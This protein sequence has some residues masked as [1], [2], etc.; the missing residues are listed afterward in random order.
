MMHRCASRILGQCSRTVLALCIVLIATSTP[1]SALLQGPLV[2]PA[3]DS[4]AYRTRNNI[5]F[6]DPND[7]GGACA[8]TAGGSTALTGGENIEKGFNYFI[9]KGLTPEQSAGIVGN[10][11]VESGGKLDPAVKQFDGGPGRGIAQWSA[12]GRWDTLLAWAAKQNRSPTDLA[13]QL[14]FLWY[15]LETT[16]K[17]SLAAVRAANTFAEAASAFMLKF[18]RPADTSQSAQ[19]G[20][21]KIAGQVLA[22]YGANGAAST[23]PAG[24]AT[25]ASTDSSPS[26]ACS[27][28]PADTVNG[29]ASSS[30]FVWPLKKGDYSRIST[31]WG[32]Y[33]SR[34]GYHTGL[35]INAS[36]KPVLAAKAGK[37]IQAGVLGSTGILAIVIDHGGGI[38]SNYQHLDSIAVKVGESVR[39]SQEIGKSGNSG[40]AQGYSTGPH[41]HFGISTVPGVISVRDPNASKLTKDPLK[42]LPQDGSVP[43][44]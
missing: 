43:G 8:A 4:N 37:V 36:Y 22:R 13:T 39:A 1:A 31:C 10:L 44:C 11:I 9:Q 18:E 6:Y 33:K 38:Y 16:E 14:D 40:A 26:A 5:I 21:A 42:Y 27:G 7:I 24:T 12:G 29:P 41:L 34:A 2:N 23:V 35:D 19:A 3:T 15:E 32:G 17:A 25:A 30:G 20:R 28:T